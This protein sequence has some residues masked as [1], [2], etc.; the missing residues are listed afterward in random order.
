LA[1][2]GPEELQG[3]QKNIAVRYEIAS[4]SEFI[5]IIVLGDT[6]LV[7]LHMK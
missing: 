5:K 4:V 7:N 6:S 2:P 3:N 1:S